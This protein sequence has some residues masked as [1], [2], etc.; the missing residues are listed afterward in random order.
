M[1]LT[2][3]AR[4]AWPIVGAVI[5]LTTATPAARQQREPP[6]SATHAAA[7]AGRVFDEDGAPL[8]GAL[9]EALASRFEK[10]QR[11][12]APAASTRTDDRG[13]F[14]LSGLPPGRYYVSARHPSFSSGSTGPGAVKYGPTFFPGVSSADEARAVSVRETGDIARI[15]IRV[16]LVP[17]A[18]VSGRIVASDGR[19]LLSGAVILKPAGGDGVPVVGPEDVWIGP[20]GEFSFSRVP[21]GHYRISARGETAVNGAA[22]IATFG[23]IVEGR[24]VDNVQMILRPGATL[25]GELTLDGARETPA[26]AL[27]TLRVRAPFPDGAP[28]DAPSGA[29]QSNGRFVLRG[30]MSGDHQIAVEGLPSPWVVKSVLLRGRDVADLGVEVNEGQQLRGAR[31]TIGDRESEVSGRVADR[32]TPVADAAVLLYSVAPQFWVR[33]HRRMRMTRTDADGRFTVRGLP[34]GEYLAIA[35]SAIDEGDLGRREL[36]ESM[37]SLA[38]PVSISG[39]AVR[40]TIDL[41]FL[42]SV[43]G[44][45]VPTR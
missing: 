23:I 28:G 26:P 12:L 40:V 39:Q 21:P 5:A 22:L 19:Q 11:T 2:R 27:S 37:R 9:V 44:A 6:A 43:Q 7:I 32:G 1:T 45:P 13:E 14:G 3:R 33:T 41:P 25:E 42:A 20:N 16:R 30:L 38:T 24:D 36:L 10:G 8:P 29:V 17:S 34:D 4:G 31:I 15:E 18:R 35:S